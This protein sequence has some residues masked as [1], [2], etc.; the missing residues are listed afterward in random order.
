MH[1]KKCIPL[2]K[3]RNCKRWDLAL[4]WI[5][6]PS[7]LTSCSN[8]EGVH[9]DSNLQGK[10][11]HS[12]IR[13]FFIKKFSPLIFGPRHQVQNWTPGQCSLFVNR[14]LDRE[15]SGKTRNANSD[16]R[17]WE[18]QTKNIASIHSKESSRNPSM[19]PLHNW[20]ADLPHTLQN[21]ALG[22]DRSGW[23][24]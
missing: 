20:K 10:H 24:R 15:G 21:H 6:S 12:L 17:R 2:E 3:L 16:I 13:W 14:H 9:H 8:L 22:V 5:S 4:L 23:T 7:P 19:K 11:F 18:L 1:E